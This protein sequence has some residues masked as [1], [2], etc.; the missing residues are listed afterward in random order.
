[1]MLLLEQKIRIMEHANLG[2]RVFAAER[3]NKKRQ[4]CASASIFWDPD[5]I[6]FLNEES[7]F[8]DP[9]TILFLNEEPIWNLI[10]S[11]EFDIFICR[12][13]NKKV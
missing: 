13:K 10:S 4:L 11:G 6:F 7:K 1:M 2:E 3:I 8:W 9:D 12:L 5:T